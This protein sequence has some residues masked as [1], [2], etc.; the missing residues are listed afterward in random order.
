MAHFAKYKGID[1]EKDV[2]LSRYADKDKI[3]SYH[4]D[5]VKWAVKNGLISGKDN[6]KRIDPLGTASRA[7]CSKM[8][9]NGYKV[10]Y[11]EKGK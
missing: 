4:L 6:G 8:L 1:V 11:S 5:A 3:S 9:L 2:D 7:E 10:I